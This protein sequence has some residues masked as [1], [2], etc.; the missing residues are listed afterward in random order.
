M[1]ARGRGGFGFGYEKDMN[2]RSFGVGELPLRPNVRAHSGRDTAGCQTRRRTL[3]RLLA[4][5]S[6]IPAATTLH[7]PIASRRRSGRCGLDIGR[8]GERFHSVS[9]YAWANSST[10]AGISASPRAVRGSQLDW[11]WREPA[12]R[13]IF[14]ARTR[15]PMGSCG[16]GNRVV[17]YSFRPRRVG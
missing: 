9:A 17:A 1:L 16:E 15:E 8:C 4:G 12:G 2:I 10:N 11:V 5:V 7:P 3:R 13:R 14:L 6:R